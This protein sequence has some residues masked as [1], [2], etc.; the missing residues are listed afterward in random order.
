M[1]ENPIAADPRP[2][3]APWDFA[4]SG[5]VV[6]GATGL[7]GRCLV[8]RLLAAGARLRTV[9]SRPPPPDFPLA[10]VDHRVGDL[11]DRCFADGV[12]AGMDAAFLLAGKRGSVGIQISRAATML[13]DNLLVCYNSLDAACRAGVKRMVYAST[14]T[15][16]PPMDVYREDLAWSAPPHPGDQYVAWAKRMAEKLIEAQQVQYGRAT[17]AVVRPVN[18][19]GPHDNF[20]PATALVVP[21]LIGRALSGENPLVVWGDGSAVRDFL[22]VSDAVDGLLLAFDKGI[23]QGAINLGSGRGH[24]IREVVNAVVAATGFA[25]EVVWDSAKPAG[26]ARKVADTTRA[27]EI[28]GFA[29]KVD[30]GEA[31]RRTV[32][33]YRT[34][35]DRN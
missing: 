1:P 13:T 12:M 2:S 15:V 20:D 8:G 7:Y 18:T 30:L 11:R 3:G 5:I 24:S 17:T 31:I 35:R 26:E 33:W 29:P 25:G 28:L 23:G 16:Y 32:D 27:R 21:A 6:T 10:A 14:V 9:S 22:F 19:F 4:G 34:T